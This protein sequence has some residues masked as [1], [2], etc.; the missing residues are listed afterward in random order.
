MEKNRE[1]KGRKL[2]PG[3]HKNPRNILG[4]FLYLIVLGA[5]VTFNSCVGGYVATEPSYNEIYNRPASPGIGYIWIDG[6]W[7]WN[8]RSRIYVHDHGYWTRPR[9]GRSYESG[10]WY[11]GP[12]GQYWVRGRWNRD[13]EASR[14]SHDDNK[15]HR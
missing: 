9:S 13:N 10:H 4:I 7:R 12:R 6:D 5:S 15:T 14:S 3:I 1:S 11:S 8:H 2:F